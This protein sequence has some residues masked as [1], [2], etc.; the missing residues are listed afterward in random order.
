MTHLTVEATI[1]AEEITEERGVRFFD[2]ELTAKGDAI[3][4]HPVSRQ[5]S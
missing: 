2:H 3:A 4:R 1:I 5:S